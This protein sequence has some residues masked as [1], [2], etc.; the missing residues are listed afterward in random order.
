MNIAAL[1]AG[2]FSG[3]IGGMGMG[4]GA[5]LIIYLSLFTDT[6]QLKAQGI[7]L[8]F[9]IP[10]GLTALIIYT[11]KKQI[12]WK[13]VLPLA[14]F[15]IIGAFLGIMLTKFF[16]NDWLSKIFGGFLILMAVKEFF[17]KKVKTVEK[18]NK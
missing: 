12:K 4:G 5:V 15:G 6:P 18:D 17:S 1:L 3:I 2:L 13:T 7:N 16:G 11:I 14:A 8:L 10:I 9:F